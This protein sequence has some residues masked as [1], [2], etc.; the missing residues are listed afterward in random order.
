MK[1][2]YEISGSDA[3]Q[4]GWVEITGEAGQSGYLW[5]L[6]AEGETRS[7]FTDYLE[8]TMME[9]EKTAAASHIVDAG[10]TNDTDYAALGANSGTEGLFAAI[11]DR[12]NVTTGV[13]GVN[14]ATDLAEFD[15][16]LAEF[17]KQGAIEENMLFVNRVSVEDL[18]TSISLTSAI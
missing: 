12:G 10:G 4:V 8:M 9:A 14:A 18:T 2:V 6:K 11:E 16:I 3:S 1:D 13:T 5:Y 7:R 17:D 15:A